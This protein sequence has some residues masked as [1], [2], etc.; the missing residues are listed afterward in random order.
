M[1]SLVYWSWIIGWN[2]SPALLWLECWLFSSNYHCNLQPSAAGTDSDMHLQQLYKWMNQI[3]VDKIYKY[4]DLKLYCEDV[5]GDLQFESN[6]FWITG[7][8]STA[9]GSLWFGFLMICLHYWK[10]Y[11]VRL[12]MNGSGLSDPG[13]YSVWMMVLKVNIC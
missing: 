1:N 3:Y 13:G 10:L 6:S 7:N 4:G 11:R 9:A 2:K 8:L 5:Y 12:P